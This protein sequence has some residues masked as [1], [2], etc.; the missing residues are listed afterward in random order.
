MSYLLSAPRRV[1]DEPIDQI[2]HIEH[3]QDGEENREQSEEFVV[4]QIQWK[5]ALQCVRDRVALLFSLKRKRV[6][7]RGLMKQ[8]TPMCTAP[9][10]L[11][12]QPE[13]ER[14]ER[15]KEGRR[16]SNEYGIESPCCSA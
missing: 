3:E 7:E 1:D 6:R 8:C 14:N 9:G 13:V 16:H 11:V 12:A 15:M 2:E 4:V 10:C 5:D